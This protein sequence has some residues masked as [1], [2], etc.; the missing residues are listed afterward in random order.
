MDNPQLPLSSTT[1][2]PQTT[3][4]PSNIII[5]Q[6]SASLPIT[7]TLDDSNYPLWSQLM[8]MRIGTQ[9]KSGYLTGM[10]MKS[11]HEDPAYDTWVTENKRIK[12][13]LIVSMSPPLMQRFIRLESAHDIWGAAPRTFYDSSDESC[14]FE[15]NQRSFN[16]KQHGRPFSVYYDEL[17]LIFQAIDHRLSSQATTV[18]GVVQS[19]SVV[20][21][22]RVYIFLSGLDPD[23]AQVRGEI[24][25]KDPKLDLEC[26]YACVRR[27]VQQHL[28]MNRSLPTSESSAFVTQT[29][30]TPLTVSVPKLRKDTHS[31][32]PLM[33]SHGG[34]SGHSKARCYEIVGYPDWWDFT[35]RP[36]R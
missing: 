26:T 33:C 30:R 17:L 35:K 34:G 22:L 1:T 7:V 2:L 23:F 29:P 6:D 4:P 9:N 12:S 15:L 13:W 36:R 21:R 16:T 27:E 20:A 32:K 5:K 3:V 31:S 18:D 10:K 14:L 28:T 11:S 24:L 19:H 8:D 25:R